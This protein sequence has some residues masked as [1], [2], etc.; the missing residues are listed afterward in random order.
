MATDSRTPANSDNAVEQGQAPYQNVIIIIN[1]ASGQDRPMLGIMN[2]AF[3][4]AGIHWD[5]RITKETGDAER[6][7]QEAVAAG[8][9]AV[10]VYGGDG[11]VMEVANGLYGSDVPLAIFPGGT[12]NVMSVELGIPG[13]LTEA[14]ALVCSQ[15]SYVRQVDVGRLRDRSFLLRVGIGFEADVINRTERE[16]KNRMGTLAYLLTGL[17]ALGE[18]KIARYRLTLDDEVIETEGVSLMI[19][20]S[21][22]MGMTNMT[23]AKNIDVSDGLLDVVVIRDTDVGSLLQ[24]AA[25][26]VGLS[27]PL[28]HWQARHVAVESDPIQH[29]ICDGEPMDD[30]PVEASVTPRALH[31]I[32]PRAALNTTQAEN[33]DAPESRKARRGRD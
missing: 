15:N 5:V 12:A 17:Q 32:V 4:K 14:T 6:F 23:F 30:T 24:V 9:D 11:T 19:A 28:P 21:G 27:D 1:P 3:H 31:V 29:V 2:R 13:D 26:A 20:N 7:A 16:A 8:V 18:R 25:S 33:A 22:N 10:G